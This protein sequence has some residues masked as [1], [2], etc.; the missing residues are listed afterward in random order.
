[1]PGAVFDTLA[2]MRRLE[3][4]GIADPHADALRL[5][6]DEGA[7]TGAGLARLEARSMIFIVGVAGLIAAAVELL[8]AAAPSAA[9]R[10]QRPCA[11]R[12]GPEIAKRP[13]GPTNIQRPLPAPASTRVLE[14]RAGIEPT[15]TDLQSAVSPFRHRAARRIHPGAR[16]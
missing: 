13:A 11:R 7:A 2:C 9:H 1:M 4:A 15:Y 8:Q 16:A 10:R 14:A 3:E 12:G 6:V 5:A